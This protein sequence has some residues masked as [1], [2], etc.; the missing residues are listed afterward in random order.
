MIRAWW[1][2]LVSHEL[3]L[4]LAIHRGY[5][6][7]IISRP[8]Q[9][10]GDED[11]TALTEKLRTVAS[12][13]LGEGELKYGV[14]SGERDRL[15]RAVV[16]LITEK[17]TGRP[18]AFNALSLIET[19]FAGER[20]DILHLGLVI[21]DPEVR[22]KGLSSALYGLTVLVLFL[23]GGLRPRWISNVTQVPAIVG[24]VAETFSNVFPTPDEGARQSFAH[25]SLARKI[26]SGHRYV[27]GVGQ[28]AGFEE[29]KSIITS[30][31]TGGSD[32][33]KKS[34]DSAPKHRDERYNVFCRDMLDYQRGDDVLQ[35]GQMDI[36]AARRYLLKE[37]PKGS[38]P[39]LAGAAL[40]LLVQRMVLPVWYWLD[41]ASPYGSL[42]PRKARGAS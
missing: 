1:H 8:G 11:L 30:A 4:K 34:F 12:R 29:D 23:R 26:M 3:D 41:T 32:D 38:L 19:E 20:V 24:M 13:A 21:V 15:A 22:G 39:A 28:E 18:V 37:A 6:T 9:I 31:Y 40:F 27:F 25:L 42:R 5:E 35:I 17:E 14:F 7:R 2:A 16:T 10:L 33:L 36:A